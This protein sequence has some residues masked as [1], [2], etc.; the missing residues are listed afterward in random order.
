MMGMRS[1]LLTVFVFLSAASLTWAQQSFVPAVIAT[2]GSPSSTLYGFYGGELVRSQD[3]GKTWTPLYITQAGLTQPPMIGFAIDPS[4]P[5]NNTLYYAT[6]LAAGS[7]WKSSDAG[8]TW[9]QAS[10]GL[11]VSGGTVGYFKLY[12]DATGT[13][14]YVQ[15]GNHLYRS[16]NGATSWL[17]QGVLPTPSGSMIISDSARNQMYWI[18]TA[19]LTV[20]YSFSEGG[21]WQPTLQV[22]GGAGATV[23][24]MGVPYWDPND[25]YVTVNVPVSGPAVYASLDGAAFA[26]QSGTG[27]GPFTK[28]NSAATEAA[29]ALTT[30]PNAFFRTVNSGQSWQSLGVV[31]LQHFSA[32]AVDPNVRTTLYGVETQ[33]NMPNPITLIQSLDSG[34]S[35]NPISST[36]TPTIAKPA[37][38]IN[39]TLEQGA[40]YSAPFTVQLAENPAWQTQVTLTT[41]GE[42]WLQIAAPAGSTPLADSFTISTAG[43]LPGVYN[44]TITISAPQTFNKSV[45][46]PVQLTIEPLGALGPGYLVSTVAGNGNPAGGATTGAP[47]KVAVGDARAV[48]IDPSGNVDFSAGNRLWQLNNGQLTVL[49]GNGIDASNGDGS[50]PTNASIADPDAIAFDTSGNAYLPE[51]ALE[52]VRLYS[53]GNISTPLFMTLF[54]QPVGAHTLVIDPNLFMLLPVPNGI[55]RYD[56]SKLTLSI[57]EALSNPYSM[58]EDAS[59]NLYVSDMG[60]NQVL[61]ISPSGTVTVVAGMGLPGY[62]GDGGPAAQALLNAPAGI[63]F[64]AQGTLYIADS[65]N[66]RIRT[67]TKD[68]NIHTIAGSGLP[69]FA[70]DGLTADFA[71]FLNPLGVAVDGSGNVYVADAGNFRLRVL[72]PQ[73]TP[74][75]QPRTNLPPIQGPNVATTLSP[76]SIFS[77][78]GTNLAPPGYMNETSSNTWPRDMN[79]VSV[80][81][82]GVAAPL[83]YVSPTQI[84]G[85]IPFETA[86]GTATA[87]IA[88]NGS[89]PAQINFP[90]TAAQPDVLV[91]GGTT[92][93]VAI[94]ETGVENTPSTPAHPGDI[95][96]VYLTGI[97]IPSPTVPTGAP[98]PSTLPLATINPNYTPSITLNN[99]QANISYLGYAPGFPAL[100]QANFAIPQGMTGNLSLVVT[101]TV[102]GVSYASAPTFI[103][104]Q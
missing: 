46:I 73:N 59:G 42:S 96:V 94:N 50:D 76:G 63:A 37:P 97:G 82:N 68:G 79:G 35:W 87:V 61:E 95:E 36:I 56:G 102:N 9:T 25:L 80:T 55:L 41:S 2:P 18:D 5:S 103:T 57:P 72:T 20:Y 53:K 38:S 27:L 70:G 40:P 8:N 45:S 33:L 10:A 12:N 58:L 29:Y 23:A 6:A 77:L 13:Y 1:N 86:L 60:L 62:G 15:I 66:N 92:Q 88:V 83:Y 30:P 78:Y 93:A 39:L 74:V 84:N 44:S 19:T 17:L 48:A 81:I 99:Q 85:Q 3:Q 26:D 101:V 43:L 47:T 4:D 28:M 16:T 91:Q 49:A 31:G 90:V 34:N 89:L 71:S 67:V 98:S 22:P 75:P 24:S 65:G 100:V 7:I 51:Y 54:N 32:T 14:L 52:E 104:V 64:D 21:Q 11:P 69:G